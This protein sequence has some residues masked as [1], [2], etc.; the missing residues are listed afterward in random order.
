MSNP[1]SR[2]AVDR[3]KFLTLNR[4]GALPQG[5]RAARHAIAKRCALGQ[6]FH[7]SKSR[8][9][10]MTMRRSLYT[11]AAA[12]CLAGWFVSAPAQAQSVKINNHDIGGGGRGPHGAEGGVLGVAPERGLGNP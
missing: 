2:L 6:V 5:G 1:S 11:S 9:R 8:E 7:Q 10:I 12:I 4:P 3:P